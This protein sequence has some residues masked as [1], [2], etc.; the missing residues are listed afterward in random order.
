MGIATE[1]TQRLFGKPQQQYI[2][3]RTMRVA[4][5]AFDLLKI[6]GTSGTKVEIDDMRDSF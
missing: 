5:N 4:C 2:S 1:L 3:L 6:A